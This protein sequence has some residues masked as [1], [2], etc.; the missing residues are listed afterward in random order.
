MSTLFSSSNSKQVLSEASIGVVNLFLPKPGSFDDP[1]TSAE[2]MILLSNDPENVPRRMLQQAR[3]NVQALN[4]S[5]GFLVET[6][7][8]IEAKLQ[9]TV[10][11]SE[12]LDQTA[13]SE[14][15]ATWI[16][17]SE[18]ILRESIVISRGFD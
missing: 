18:D 9:G 1:V 17:A 11:G 15:V 12:V 10:D 7:K 8:A 3:E 2:W 16:Q 5:V 6:R 14:K 13:Q 4:A